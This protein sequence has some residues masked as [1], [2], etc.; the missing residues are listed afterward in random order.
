MRYV[1]LPFPQCRVCV[2]SVI[3]VLFE[4]IVTKIEW[5]AIAENIIIRNLNMK[6]YSSTR[7]LLFLWVAS[8]QLYED[9]N[10]N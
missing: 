7:I 5:V 9:G 6:D 10:P 4:E 2:V 1:G 8:V 3:C